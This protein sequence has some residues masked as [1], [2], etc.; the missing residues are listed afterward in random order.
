MGGFSLSIAIEVLVAVL[1]AVTIGYCILVNR[2]LVQLRSDQSELKMIV[3]DLHAATGQAEQAIAGLR[4]SAQTA[5]QSLGGQLEMVRSLDEQLI[6]SIGRGEVLLSKLSTLTHAY[7][8]RSTA[9]PK[10][11]SISQSEI[12]LGKLNAQRRERGEIP[13]DELLQDEVAA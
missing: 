8:V 12:G 9:A 13:G 5:E 2:K 4:Q 6:G 7:Q 10:A 11:Q 3:R 1:L